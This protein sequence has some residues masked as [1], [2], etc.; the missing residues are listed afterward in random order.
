[1]LLLVLDDLD[2]YEQLVVRYLTLDIGLKRIEEMNLKKHSPRTEIKS[3]ILA[4]LPP[5][6]T[7]LVTS[8]P[9]PRTSATPN[10]TLRFST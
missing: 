9:L 10:R 8:S 7:R 5:G 2:T 6:T 3:L 4:T 1:M